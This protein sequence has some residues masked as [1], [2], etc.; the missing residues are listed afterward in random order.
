MAEEAI[1]KLGMAFNEYCEL[2]DD[3]IKTIQQL[4]AQI[5][6]RKEQVYGDYKSTKN[7]D[8]IITEI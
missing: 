6:F 4:R 8:K 7:W 3:E 1:N 2:T 5:R